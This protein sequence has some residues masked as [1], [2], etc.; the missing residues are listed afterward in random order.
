[1]KDGI[2]IQARTGST[3]LHNKIL[4]PFYKGQRI[5]DILI[6]N[7][8]VA[9]P[10][11]LVVLATT[12]HPQ[13]DVLAEVA[14]ERGIACFR[15][16]EDNVLNRFIG[17]AEAFGLE[18]I[19]RVCS[20]NPFLQVGTFRC[21]FDE[22]M[23]H[24]ADYVAYG[25]SDGRPTIKSHLGLFAELTTIDALKRIARVTQKKLYIEHVTIY[26]YTHPE[27]FSIKLLPLPDYLEGRFDLR[28]TLD[29]MADF[30]LLQ[31]L[32]TTFREETDGSVQALLRLVESRDEYRQRM[33]ENIVINEK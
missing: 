26:M 2:I 12:D 4:L 20:D 18:R 21:L 5:I 31:E 23:L 11:M 6:D 7:I 29:T 24:H 25:F 10:D 22:Y 8:K 9:C 1:M 3:R 19:I 15:G 33:L 30:T 27:E 16:D 32:Y 14:H 17:A 13:D 28:F